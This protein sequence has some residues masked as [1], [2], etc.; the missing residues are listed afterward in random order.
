MEEVEVDHQEGKGVGYK[1]LLPC[2]ANPKIFI[3]NRKL[4]LFFNKDE[5]ILNENRIQKPQM[6]Q[7][8]YFTG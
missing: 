1:G 5:P 3:F 8:S 7:T 4:L 2:G 6:Y